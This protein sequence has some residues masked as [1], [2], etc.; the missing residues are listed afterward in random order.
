MTNSPLASDMIWAGH[1]NNPRQK[2]CRVLSALE[3]VEPLRHAIRLVE[4]QT[5]QFH[6]AATRIVRAVFRVSFVTLQRL[7]A[8]RSNDPSSATRPPGPEQKRD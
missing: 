3:R 6:H 2:T 1:K 4:L 7:L 5:A 8:Y